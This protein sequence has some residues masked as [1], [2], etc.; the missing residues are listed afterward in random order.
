MSMKLQRLEVAGGAQGV[1]HVRWL[2]Y[3]PGCRRC[4]TFTTGSAVGPNWTFSGDLD[5]PTFS[6]SLLIFTTRP[7]GGDTANPEDERVTLCHL[8]VRGGK[9]EYCGDSPHELRGQ[10]VDMVDIPEEDRW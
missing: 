9:I 4:H 2:F 6:P 3:C 8:F 7:K 1:D 10:T 5:R